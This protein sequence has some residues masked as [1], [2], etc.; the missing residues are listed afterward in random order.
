MSELSPNSAQSNQLICF[1][2]GT[3]LSQPSP[4][5]IS[6]GEIRMSKTL[7]LPFRNTHCP[8]SPV[9]C[10]GNK[11]YFSPSPLPEDPII[12]S[13]SMSWASS[14]HFSRNSWGLGKNCGLVGVGDRGHGPHLSV[15]YRKRNCSKWFHSFSTYLLGT[16]YT[17]GIGMTVRN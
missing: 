1:V 2:P 5:G 16:D 15:T 11:G 12:L 13:F 4:W 9:P 6:H 17:S 10:L 3:G 14:P 8:G 7:V